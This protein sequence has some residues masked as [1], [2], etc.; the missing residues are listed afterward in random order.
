[1]SASTRNDAPPAHAEIFRILGG[2]YHSGAISCLAQLGV[3]DLV[4]SGPKSAKELAQA[5][6]VKAEPL[7][8]LLRATASIGV[9]SEGADGRF[10]ETPLSAV[11][12]SNA[13]PSLRGL[14]IMSGRE[15]HGRGWSHL[16]D[17]VRTGRPV[18]ELLGG[19]PFFDWIAEDEEEARIFDAAMTSLSMLHAPRVVG[20]Y[21]FSGLRSIVDV[22]G[23]F[24]L[25]LAKVLEAHPKL[26]GTLFDL[27]HVVERAKGG[28]LK[29]VID[30]CS[31]A[32]GDMFESVPHGADAYMMKHI[33]HDWPDEKC[34]ALLKACRRGVNPGGKLL[35]IESVIQPGNDYAPGKFLDLQ[36]LIFPGGKERTE[37][38]FRALFSA[39]GWKLTRIIDTKAPE[40]V[41]EG[42]P[43]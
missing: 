29:N 27:P 15:W 43:A 25:L 39:A 8:R 35:V 33:I 2:V 23:G 14:A 1:M 24:G 6:G 41:I 42:E 16:A 37:Q 34:I 32:S 9:L 30:R 18:P 38:E 20:N 10:S 40:S 3:P 22:A 31:F 13:Q 17:S 11:L 19:K 28:P 36:M 26:R 21:S 4:E 7:Y 5:L 12:R